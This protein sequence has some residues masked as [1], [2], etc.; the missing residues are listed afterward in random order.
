M[1]PIFQFLGKKSG[2]EKRKMT[3]LRK[4]PGEVTWLEL[5]YASSNKLQKKTFKKFGNYCQTLPLFF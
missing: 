4:S 3:S 1:D 5:A 2:K